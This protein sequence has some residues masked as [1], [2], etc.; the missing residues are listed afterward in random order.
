M[1]F[2]LQRLQAAKRFVVR[3]I[4]FLFII[5]LLPV[6]SPA[7][8]YEASALDPKITLK[9][10][11]PGGQAQ[12]ANSKSIFGIR[13]TTDSTDTRTLVTEDISFACDENTA[14]KLVSYDTSSKLRIRL[15]K[16]SIITALSFVGANDDSTYRSRK[17]ATADLYGCATNSTP[18]ASCTLVSSVSWNKTELDGFANL[19]EYTAREFANTTAY[20]YYYV[21]TTSYGEANNLGPNTTGAKSGC[22]FNVNSSYCIQYSEIYLYGTQDPA[23][24]TTKPVSSV[25]YTS[26]YA[27][28]SDNT[29]GITVN[30]TV[31][32]DVE[33][34]SLQVY[35]STS[36]ALTSPTVCGSLTISGGTSASGTLNCKISTLSS[37]GTVY[38][39]TRATDTAGNVEDAPTGADDSF[40]RDTSA[41]ITRLSPGGG[42]Q[43]SNLVVNPFY[44]ITE[45][46]SGLS[47]LT[48]FYSTNSNLSS[49][50]TCFT[51]N[52]A[53]VDT[54]TRTNVAT[55]QTCTLP[56][57]D[58][59]YYLFTVGTDFAGNVESAPSSRDQQ[60]TVD[61]TPPVYS[62]FTAGTSAVIIESATAIS[63]RENVAYGAMNIVFTTSDSSSVTT[64]LSGPDASHFLTYIGS[65]P[66]SFASAKDFENPVD[67]D[68]NGVYQVTLTLTDAAGN[69]STRNLSITV[70]NQPELTGITSSIA[71]GK[72]GAGTTIPIQVK[73]DMP[74]T[75]SE[76]STLNLK[77]TKKPGDFFNVP[78]ATGTGTDTLTFNYTSVLN[79]TSTDLSYT[80]TDSLFF[81]PSSGRTISG[82]GFPAS[83]T[84]PAPGAAGSLSANKNIVIDAIATTLTST[85][86][87][88]ITGTGATLNFTASETGT[89]YIL[90]LSSGAS[91]P[92]VATVMAQ[93]TAVAKA[94]GSMLATTNSV[95]VTGLSGATSYR[96]YVVGADALGNTNTSP[97]TISFTTL[98]ADTTKPVSSGSISATVTRGDTAT[99]AYTATDAGGLSSITVYYS[100]NADLSSAVS[101]GTA[102]ISGASASGNITCT[103]PSTDATYYFYTQVSDVAGNVEDAPAA[104]SA[105]DSIIRDTT[106]AL[107]TGPSGSAGA[108]TSSKSIPENSTA[109]A[110]ITANETAT[111][112]ISGTDVS[113]FSINSSTGELTITSRNYESAA[114]SDSNNSYIVVVT[115]TDAAG[116]ASSQTITISITDVDE[117]AP[118]LSSTSASSITTTG[119][120]L[121]YSTDEA[122]TAYYLVYL[123]SDSAPTAST[124]IAQGTAVSKGSSSVSSGSNTFSASGL[125]SATN[126]K[127]YLVVTDATGNNSLVSTISFTTDTN[128]PSITSFNSNRTSTTSVAYGDTVTVT[129]TKFT[130]AT[131][132][133]IGGTAVDTFTV[134][135][136]TTITF[137][138]NKPCCTAGKVTVTNTFGTATSTDDLIP[139]PQLPV[140]T[141]HPADTSKDV[142]QSV[143]FSV[144][145]A[146]PQDGGTLSYQWRK[147]STAISGETSSSYTFTT[148]SLSDT[149]TYS[150]VVTNTVLTSSSSVNSN[151]ATLT[152]GKGDQAP[153]IITSTSGTYLTAL[154]L[155]TSGGSTGG[156]LTFSTGTTGCLTTRT[157]IWTLTANGA[158][159]CV[160]TATMAGDA[161]YNSVSSGST[162]IV[163]GRAPHPVMA[164]T[165]TE[166]TY[167][168]SVR[169]DYSGGVGTG[170]ISFQ[171]TS[172]YCDVS[173]GILTTTRATT[174]SIRVIQNAS[175]DYESA[176]SMYSDVVMHPRQFT[177]T[178]GN[179][180]ADYTGSPVVIATPTTY[181]IPS[182][183]I[184]GNDAIT[185]VTYAYEGTGSTVYAKSTSLPTN[186]GTYAIIAETITMGVD[187]LQSYTITKVNGT[188]VVS[189]RTLAQPNAPNL[190]TTT[191]VLKSLTASWSAVTNAVGY[192]I[193]I[194]ENDG[195]TLLETVTVSSGTSKVITASDF[196]GIADNRAYKIK[197]TATGDANNADSIASALSGSATT[198]RS[199]SITYDSNTATSGS[200][201]APGSWITGDSATVIASNSG[202]LARTGYTFTGWNTAPNGSG[203]NY[204]ANGSATYNSTADLVLYAKWSANTLNITYKSDFS[205]G[206]SDVT[207]T[208]TAG[209]PFTL[210]A[211]TFTH[212][213][214]AFAGWATTSGGT[215]SKADSATV[216]LLVDTTYFAQWTA[217]NYSI[218]YYG[219][220]STG[221]TVPVDSTNYNIGGTVT[222][223]GNDGALT[224]TG[225]S[226][227]GW[228]IGQADT[229]TVYVLNSAQETITVGSSS[230]SAYAKWSKDTYYITYDSQQGTSVLNSAY[231][232]GDTVT[233]AT[234]STRTGYT[235]AG[236]ASTI[237]GSSVG[238]TYSPPGIG[239]VTLYAKWTAINYQITYDSNTA[240]SGSVP[241]DSNN[242]NIG[243]RV[244]VLGNIS[245]LARAGYTWS[246]WNTASNG[247]GTTYLTGATFTMG[248]SDVTLYAKW[249]PIDYT[250]TYNGNGATSGSVPIDSNNYHVNEV[251]SISSSNGITRTG[252]TFAGWTV[253]SDNTGTVMNSGYALTFGASN[254]TVYAKWSANTYTVTFAQNGAS[255]SPSATSASYTT[256]GAA[257]TL[258]TV[259]TMS[260]PG[261]SFSGWSTTSNGTPI[262]GSY[263][264]SVDVTLVALWT[265]VN[266]TITYVPNGGSSTPTQSSLQIGQSFTLATGITRPNGSQ[267][268]VYA[269]VGWNDG[270]STYQ[271]GY[272]YQVGSSNVTLTASWVRVFEVSYAFNGSPDTP[273]ANQLKFDG[274]SI[275][276]AA[277]PSY[278]GHIFEGWTDQSNQMFNAG[279]NYTV[280]SQH[281][282]IRAVWSAI[283][284]TVTYL[285]AGGSTTPISGSYTVGQTFTLANA[286]TRTGYTFTGWDNGS[287]KL[288][289]GTSIVVGTSDMTFTAQW[290]ANVYTVTYDLNG[291]TGTAIT[292]ASY[293][294]GTSAL[295]LPLVGDRVRTNHTFGGW[296][297]TKGGATVGLTYTPTSTLTLFAVWTL[298]QYAVTFN[299]NAVNVSNTTET[300]TAGS[301]ALVLPTITRAGFIFKGWYSASTNG[302][303]I[304]QAGANYTPASNGSVYARWV[305][306]SLS[307]VNEADLQSLGSVTTQNGL[308]SVNTYITPDSTVSVTIPAGALPAATVVKFDLL[309]PAAVR[310]TPLPAEGSHIL[311]LV[312]SWIAQ[313]GTVPN[314]ATGKPIVMTV[315]SS[316]IKKGATVYSIVGS[317]VRSLGTATQ[318]GSVTVEI[319]EDP[320]VAIVKT[321]PG[322][323]TNVS[324]TNGADISS[325]VT[326]DAPT[327]DGGD[328]IANYTVTSSR[329]EVCVTSTRSCAFNS[330]TNGI[331]YTFTV[332]AANSVGFSDPSSASASITPGTPTPSSNNST[333]GSGGGGSAAP[334]GLQITLQEIT[335]IQSTSI[336]TSVLISWPGK[337]FA[338]NICATLVGATSCDQVKKIDVTKIEQL[339][340]LPTGGYLLSSEIRNLKSA[341][342]YAIY[343]TMVTEG[344][345]AI[346]QTRV[347]K[348]T[349]GITLVAP[350]AISVEFNS[351]VSIVVAAENI[352]GVVRTWSAD[353]LPRALKLVKK[354]ATLEISGPAKKIGTYFIDIAATDSDDVS[355]TTRLVLTVT[356]PSAR[357]QITSAIMQPKQISKSKIV[358]S[359]SGPGAFEVIYN[360]KRLCVT[361]K[362]SCMVADI[363]GPLSKVQVVAR[364]Q[365]G[366][367]MTSKAAAYLSPVK[368]IEVGSSRFGLNSAT[369]SP[370]EKRAVEKLTRILQAKGFAQI[371]VSGYTD[372][373]GSKELNANLSTA[374]ARNTYA[375]LSK[376][377]ALKS[378]TVTLSGK[379]STNPIASNATAAG[380][381]L[382]RR[383]VISIY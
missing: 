285:P 177:I 264:T 57:S 5:Q 109:V 173:Q 362:Y 193:N 225:Y 165:T 295:T 1:D 328:P 343:A 47:S 76:T 337:A 253:A 127:G 262:S 89:Y 27:N 48:L 203:S 198:N 292:N 134:V 141:A 66:L 112:T 268:E 377:L 290:T 180:G 319:T 29:S 160:V 2:S 8:T 70:L 43:K 63:V 367:A 142:G 67:A 3:A 166:G 61:N 252:Y 77:I 259:G 170:N 351:E 213:G 175:I 103:F 245:N 220:N 301:A 247:S 315:T 46:V 189:K 246:G 138:S 381:A 139:L 378:L 176:T 149:G 205:G 187:Q 330:L 356:A 260:K 183:S 240:T 124:V 379:A 207:E 280:G 305:Q 373:T 174:C 60:V 133:A 100:T 78:Y 169:L 278:A 219:N 14:T 344:Q 335:K 171:T 58:N 323:P 272:T 276:L 19:T 309:D 266:Y 64:T 36:A 24:D 94:S 147:G 115:A 129:G 365:S 277:A 116:N 342:Q 227:V 338:V 336:L 333:S 284:Y 237:G 298:N 51:I 186:A 350:S 15:D 314:T 90:V 35:A 318:N 229:G 11:P 380:R 218:T 360:D 107:I 273:P 128:A 199:Y 92:T 382:N 117:I 56:N 179:N 366:A 294:Y 282:L 308:G 194:F 148:S 217:I 140:I 10:T 113:F 296:S 224:R 339:E 332:R 126:Y 121:N 162:N 157:S 30:Y 244:T 248:S 357:I 12:P 6:I 233:L 45:A 50:V 85:T 242:Y 39:F 235:F 209:T 37:D 316:S 340:I 146:A 226:F 288:A 54:R 168:T 374:R 238:S 236:W 82:N 269:F 358:W 13:C 53:S 143:T 291:G 31:S 172:P 44:D 4:P 202:N 38:L 69:F 265:A 81:F 256:G 136:S 293:T 270:T 79:D 185:G 120:D 167:G 263:T 181:S 249:V 210:K 123:A 159:T 49:P 195:T 368:P 153:L 325:V 286:I 33:L 106:P 62:S 22:P 275:T 329:G 214:Y 267:G 206:G 154:T 151:G 375:H 349:S 164:V 68:R 370:T 383:A 97:Y 201:P 184:I 327:T 144:T 111:W 163:F 73:F 23:I 145:V 287:Q 196:P 158:K 297:T 302:N 119:A 34:M 59:Y 261:Y 122:G 251:V 101:C 232:I 156:A 250:I 283:N 331:T 75:V 354:D 222:I 91:A 234:G 28:S 182:F 7:L 341:S 372:S 239:T 312:V 223:K 26:A 105:D 125:S 197:V 86:A 110:T 274:A 281:Y 84:L 371:V 303:L 55:N 150:V 108:G 300:Y 211:N 243:G 20:Q 155:T 321:R 304:G 359:A 322:A 135:N 355:A 324:A 352:S 334:S 215:V 348:T 326:W 190:S 132:V 363:V 87:S 118:L 40:I 346:S 311:S 310:A 102:A 258:P 228:T 137:V 131:A 42:S 52:F 191:G 80:A 307:G 192:R 16:P 65:S 231:Q 289:P 41:P 345:T 271:P 161:N 353:G 178:V 200:A 254:I 221:G 152:M 99:V 364:D 188:L 212:T 104:G 74:V 96:A 95:S 71:D 257:I 98:A 317:S 114:D 93:G 17:I 347:I 18:V 320:E 72:Y 21:T 25:S 208:K 279:A 83:L 255:G 230:F 299:G 88:S 306:L 361:T 369:L 313:D 216:T 376:Y 241:T 130:G 32:D 204:A 9:Y